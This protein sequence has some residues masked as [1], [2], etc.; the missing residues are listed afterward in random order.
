MFCR[1]CGTEIDDGVK[2][3]P[4]C[5]GAQQA[6]DVAVAEVASKSSAIPEYPKASSELADKYKELST[7]ELIKVCEQQEPI[8]WVILGNRYQDGEGVEQSNDEA[9]KWYRKSADAGEPWGINNLGVAYRNAWGVEENDEKAAEFYHQAA[10]SGW[11]TAMENYAWMLYYGRGAEKDIKEAVKWY[12]LGAERGNAYCQYMLGWCFNSGEGV[13]QDYDKAVFWYQK[14]ADQNNADALINLGYM[15]STGRGVQKD[16]TKKIELYEK[17][18]ELGNSQAMHNLGWSYANASGVEKNIDLAR[19][20][21]LKAAEAG[22]SDSMQ[23]LAGMYENGVGVSKSWKEAKKWY[24]KASDNGNKEADFRAQFRMFNMYDFGNNSKQVSYIKFYR[25]TG[26]VLEHK[27]SSETH[28]SSSGGGGYVG[29]YGG[30]VEAAQVHSK[31]ITTDDIWIETE[32]GNEEK[33]SLT[34]YDVALRS[35]QKISIFYAILEGEDSGPYMLLVNHSDGQ[36]HWLKGRMKFM[37]EKFNKIYFY[38]GCLSC[39]LVIPMLL[40][41]PLFFMANSDGKKVVKGMD[42]H[43]LKIEAWA[44]K[45]AG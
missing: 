5:G 28:V 34:N 15:Y 42:S 43:L 19:E 6:G 22:N 16:L 12:R 44:K 17:S 33:I 39:L 7:D 30:H 35:G 4:S 41:I 36:T 31:V 21:Y 25:T 23:R 37:Q 26:T 27:R 20:W 9:F 40:N 29:K 13:E 45:N 24:Q 11:P 3:C 10:K 38:F 18:A 2:F 1:D 8:A 32:N 14:A